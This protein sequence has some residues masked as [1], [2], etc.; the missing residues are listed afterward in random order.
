MNF[1]SALTSPRF[2]CSQIIIPLAAC[3]TGYG[4]EHCVICLSC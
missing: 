3:E 2:A 4:R 1:S